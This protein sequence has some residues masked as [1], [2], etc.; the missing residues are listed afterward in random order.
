MS[1][2]SIKEAMQ[3]V[4][5][6]VS[7]RGWVYRV[8]GSNERVFIIL[9]DVTNIIQC[10]VEKNLVSKDVWD[11]AKKITVESSCELKGKVKKDERAPTGFEVEVS[12][13]R[14][15]GLAEPFPITKDKSEEF[16]YDM[17]HLWL[18][19]RRL[20]AIMKIRSSVFEAI[21]S[22]FRSRG[23]YEITPPI[24]TPVACEGGSTLFEVK[25][26]NKKMYLTQSW[27]LYAE[28][29][30]SSLEKIYCNSPCFRAERSKTSRH[31][32]EFYM[33]EMEVAWADLNDIIKYGEEL[34]SYIVQYVLEKNS[35]ELK[36]IGRDPE[37]LKN[38]KPPFPRITYDEALK[39]LEK[40]GIKIPWGKDLRTIEEDALVKHFDKPVVVTN[41][42][43][44]VKAFYMPDDPNHPNTVL[45]YDML[46]PEG[47]GEIIGGSQRST[48]IEEIKRK[49]KR[50]GEDVKKYQWY[51]DSR[52]YGN[53][54]HSGFGLGVERVISW[55]CKLDNI[56]EATPFPRTIK[57]FYP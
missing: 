17:R 51:L 16:L 41:Y 53:V 33:A 32:S 29:L 10:L 9:R 48:D 11:Q 27:Q 7:I 31:L 56:K 2:I 57:R 8:R 49:L 18:R 55:I 54:P 44:E 6:E 19:S 14:I 52:R 1:F 43:S 35:E 23:F 45:C 22:F 20:T 47:Y 34:V 15:V 40:D 13:L 12:D 38:I 4:G 24:L 39:I 46:A 25:Y 50:D 37:L 28:V 21:D 3:K 30:I 36:L 5:Q 42:P 26:Y